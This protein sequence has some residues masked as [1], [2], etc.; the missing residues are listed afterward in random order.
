MFVANKPAPFF[1]SCIAAKRYYHRL[2]PIPNNSISCSGALH[3]ENPLLPANSTNISPRCGL[4]GYSGALHL[5][6]SCFPL[7]LSI[8]RHA[9]ACLSVFHHSNLPSFHYSTIPSFHF[10]TIPLF[11]HSII[12]FFHHS[13]IPPFHFSI[14]PSFPNK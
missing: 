14:I 7:I 3:L 10:S 4:P 5:H 2:N 13:I 1:N 9:V 12:P 11:H 8:L 6:T